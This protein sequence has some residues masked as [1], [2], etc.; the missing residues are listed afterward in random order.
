MWTTRQLSYQ[1]IWIKAGYRLF[2]VRPWHHYCLLFRAIQLLLLFLAF[3]VRLRTV[4]FSLRIRRDIF[5]GC[6][7]HL[8]HLRYTSGFCPCTVPFVFGCMA[9][10]IF[11]PPLVTADCTGWYSFLPVTSKHIRRLYQKKQNSVT[12]YLHKITRYFAK[13]CREQGITCVVA[14]D[15]R[16][17]RKGKDLG[18]RTNQK[19]HNLPYNRLYS[20]MEYKLKIW[21]PFCKT[22]RKLYQ[23]VQSAVTGSRE[24][25]CRAVQTERERVVQRGKQNL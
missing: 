19:F 4:P 25:I 7:M 8:Q 20:M 9:V 1:S 6:Y 23:P 17:I 12:D 5:S 10:H 13:Y 11:F 15:I 22:G 24:K 18:H 16:N 2:R 21:D 14:G 3:L